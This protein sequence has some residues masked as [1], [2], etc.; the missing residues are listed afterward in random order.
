MEWITTKVEKQHESFVPY[1]YQPGLKEW[2]RHV[3]H[4]FKITFSPVEGAQK[5]RRGVG[6]DE[7]GPTAQITDFCC[8]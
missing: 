3:D 6:S 2:E 5:Q 8:C 4:K 7:F 1:Q